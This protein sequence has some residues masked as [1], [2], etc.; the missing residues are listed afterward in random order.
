MG[1][2]PYCTSNLLQEAAVL[3]LATIRNQDSPLSNKSNLQMSPLLVLIVWVVVV[4][5]YPRLHP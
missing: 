5:Q 2:A 1:D 3:D 4:P